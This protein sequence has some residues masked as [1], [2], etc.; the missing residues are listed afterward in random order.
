MG[1]LEEPGQVHDGVG[2]VEVGLEIVTRN[3]GL[4][5]CR[6]GRL[7]VRP[8]A[9]DPEDGIY[10]LVSGEDLDHAGADVARRTNNHHAHR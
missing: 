6:L 8:S 3:V 9:G 2:A 1:G 4:H 7:P 5:P 10:L